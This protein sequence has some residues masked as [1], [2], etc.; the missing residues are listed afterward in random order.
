MRIKTKMQ[1]WD[2][3]W[4]AKAKSAVNI[5]NNSVNPVIFSE[6]EADYIVRWTLV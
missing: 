1:N 2:T 3:Q 4:Q 5:H 6:A